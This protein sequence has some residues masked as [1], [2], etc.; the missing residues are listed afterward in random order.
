MPKLTENLPP[1]VLSGTTV[2]SVGLALA[3]LLA[4]TFRAVIE[5]APN[6]L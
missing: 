3:W 1:P 6:P 2:L 4:L 5:R